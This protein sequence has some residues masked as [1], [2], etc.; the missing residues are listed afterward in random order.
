MVKLL[1]ADDESFTRQGILETIPWKALNI[2]EVR[3]AYDGQNALE[4][5]KDFEPDILLTDVRMPR[6]NGIE[7]SFKVRE[8][9][10]NCSIIFMSGFSDKEY[11][12]IRLYSVRGVFC[13][14][15][16]C[17]LADQQ[18]GGCIPDEYLL[19]SGCEGN[20]LLRI[21]TERR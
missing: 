2:S 7:L 4:I 3:E 9:Y 15:V 14:R 20:Y 13:D 11:C 12:C 18:G 17:D 19:C 21:P 8:L 16:Y 6:L 5:I 1:I 10:P